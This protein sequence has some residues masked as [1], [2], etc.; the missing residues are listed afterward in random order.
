MDIKNLLLRENQGLS[1]NSTDG[2]DRKRQREASSFDDYISK[3]T[4]NGEVFKEAL[5]LDDF[6][7][8]L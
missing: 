2:S 8:I 7:A 3:A 1:S 6:V 4:N 5:K